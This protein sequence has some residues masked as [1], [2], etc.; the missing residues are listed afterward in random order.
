MLG[1]IGSYDRVAA[2]TRLWKRNNGVDTQAFVPLQFSLGE[3]FQFDWSEDY[4][5][6]VGVNKK[7]QVAHTKLSY[8]RAFMVRGYFLQTHEMLY[9]AHFHSLTALGGVPERGIY[10]NTKTAVD[11]VGKGK[12]RTIN[13]RFLAMSSHYLFE[14]DFCNPAA[15][16]EKGQVEKTCV[17]LGH[18]CFTTHLILAHSLSLIVGWSNAAKSC[19]KKSPILSLNNKPSMRCGKKS[20]HG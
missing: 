8:S 12:D 2:Y 14:P 4:A 18:D 10:D 1:Y 11:K 6:I 15:G 3:A 9:D 7:L 16:W 17:M 5:V 13:K 20:S 19:G